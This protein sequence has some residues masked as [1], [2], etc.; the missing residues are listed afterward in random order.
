MTYGRACY[1]PSQK[2]LV[3]QGTAG[4]DS[5]TDHLRCGLCEADSPCTPREDRS[6]LAYPPP[7]RLALCSVPRSVLRGCFAGLLYPI[8]RRM[9]S[10]A[11]RRSTVLP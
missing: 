7:V 3:D 5:A 8:L 6:A 2:H 9:S 1:Y 10:E 4:Q 11:R